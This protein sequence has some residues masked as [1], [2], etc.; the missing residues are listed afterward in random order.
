MTILLKERS[1]AR[2]KVLI[3]KHT[4]QANSPT[5]FKIWQGQK[6]ANK[7][8]QVKRNKKGVSYYSTTYFTQPW[9]ARAEKTISF[10][11]NLN[12]IKNNISLTF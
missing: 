1:R 12:E 9:F 8:N 7:Y 6:V 11:K 5:E 2:L 10:T 3:R 4:R